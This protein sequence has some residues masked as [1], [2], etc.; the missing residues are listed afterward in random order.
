MRVST[1][2]LTL[3]QPIR[4]LRD[5]EHPRLTGA[6]SLD[7]AKTTFSG[8]SYLPASTLKFALDG[9]DPTW[10]QFTGALHAEAI[11][12][13]RLSGRLGW[14]TAARPGVVAKTVANGVPAAGAAG[15]EDEPARRQS[16]R[17][18]GLLGGSWAGI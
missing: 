13:V 15:L 5:A 9:R 6:L 10:F 3:E 4:W 11:G 17:A 8:G 1:P 7:A 16:L 12:P 18:G 2:R 14:R